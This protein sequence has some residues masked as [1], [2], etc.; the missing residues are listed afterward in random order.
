MIKEGQLLSI[1][2]QNFLVVSVDYYDTK[3]LG[4]VPQAKNL[5]LRGV[6]NE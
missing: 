4:E 5:G 1:G 2:G 3:R 6:Y